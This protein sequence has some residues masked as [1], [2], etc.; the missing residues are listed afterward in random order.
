MISNL[1]NIKALWIG[2]ILFVFLG[3]GYYRYSII[4][5]T[6]RAVDAVRTLKNAD[7][8]E[9]NGVYDLLFKSCMG[10]KGFGK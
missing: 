10:K 8:N 1:K 7:A 4:V 5:C 3:C 6:E 2:I 9:A